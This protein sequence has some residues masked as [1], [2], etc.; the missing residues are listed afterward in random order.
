MATMIVFF[1]VLKFSHDCF[2]TD[3]YF[4]VFLNFFIMFNILHYP[5]NAFVSNIFR[6]DWPEEKRF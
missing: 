3:M 5:L 6:L 4:Y 2:E 1:K